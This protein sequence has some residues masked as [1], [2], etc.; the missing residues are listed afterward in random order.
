VDQ[1]NEHLK[2]LSAARRRLT[3]DRRHAAK[4][5]A[6]DNRRGLNGE[7]CNELILVQNAIEALDRAIA[8]EIQIADVGLGI[9]PTT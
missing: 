7:S 9:V 2:Q 1:E 3:A 8:D 6:Q 5:I 4:E